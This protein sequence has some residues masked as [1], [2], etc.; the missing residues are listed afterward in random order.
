[1]AILAV[2]LLIFRAVIPITPAHVV[3]IFLL[4]LIIV[5]CLVFVVAALEAVVVVKVRQRLHLRLVACAGEGLD[6]ALQ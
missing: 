6:D 4:P 3:V 5:I 1:M 2:H